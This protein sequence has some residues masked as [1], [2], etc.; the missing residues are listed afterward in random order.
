MRINMSLGENLQFLR[1]RDNMTQE[2]LAEALE[3][4]R[5][6]VSKW[7]SDSTYPEM[8][9]LLQMANMFHCSLDDLIQN[10]ISSQYVE[11][12]AHYNEHKNQLSR[13]VTIGVG[14]IL[15]GLTLMMLLSAFL[16]Q[17]EKYE[18]LSAIVFFIFIVIAVALFIMTGLQD[19]YFV[20][21]HPFI[22][23]FYTEEE[24][25][26]FHKKY[27]VLVTAGV[28]LIFVGL[29]SSLGFESFFS[30]SPMMQNIAADILSAAVFFLFITISVILFVYAGTQQEKYDIDHY[31]AMNDHNSETYKK[32]HKTGITCGIIMMT[33]T[34]I[35]LLLGFIANLWKLAPAVYAPA[36]IICGIAAIIINRKNDF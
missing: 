32:S 29:I 34:I 27:T 24:K 22:E 14:L 16:P 31:N 28:A 20:K 33:A 36:G 10:D 9:K 7:E 11:D 35:Y 5:Q 3:V 30:D 4:S 15:S 26:A 25:E 12:K 13:K 8:D 17:T 23:N 21:K 6:S 2:Q 19:D 18:S 1:K